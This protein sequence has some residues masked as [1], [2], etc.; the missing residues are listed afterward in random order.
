MS[1]DYDGLFQIIQAFFVIILLVSIFSIIVMWKI[2]TKANKAGWIALVPVYNVYT[3]FEI[4]WGNGVYFLLMFLGFIPI[5]G[6][7]ANIVVYIITLNKL[8]K[9]FSKTTGFTIGLVFLNLIFLAILAFD[10]SEYTSPNG[11]TNNTQSNNDANSNVV[12]SVN[13]NQV[14]NATE[15][16]NSN[17]GFVQPN[18]QP[19]VTNSFMNQTQPTMQMQNSMNSQMSQQVNSMNLSNTS[20]PSEI[21]NNVNNNVNNN[22]QNNIF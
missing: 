20:Q 17:I 13:M 16:I 15:N 11:M 6:P 18:T 5:V 7:I 2:F 9:A 1:L 8:S 19:Q 3:L 22:Q 4:T 21:N 12:Q 14:Q 10:N